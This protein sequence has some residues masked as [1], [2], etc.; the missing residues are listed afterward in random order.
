MLASML[1][2]LAQAFRTSPADTAWLIS[3]YACSYAVA[4]PM[5]GYLSDRVD[6]GRLLLVALLSFAI[7]GAGIVLAPTLEIAIAMRIFGGLA[8]AVL[9]PAAFALVS[10]VVDHERQAG[11]MGIVMLGMTVGI[12]AGPALAGIMTDKINWRAPF[13][14]NAVGCLLVFVIGWMTI[15]THPPDVRR[16]TAVRPRWFC[17]G[18][19]LRP[20]IAKGA[21]NG[22]GVAAFLLSGQVLQQRYGF[23][24]SGVGL[25]VAAFGIGLGVGNLSAGWLGK[26]CGREEVSLVAVTL[27]LVTA[28]ALFMST[29]LP[30]GGSLA[31]LI[32]WGVALGAGAP[33]STVILAAR[34]D[35]DKGMVL[36]FAETCNNLAILVAV[37]LATERLMM[38]GPRSAMSILA[39]GLGL[40]L[41]LTLLDAVL[42]RAR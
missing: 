5:F 25:T 33:S 30:L 28:I 34:A 31:C 21:W 24:A 12:A 8:S 6:R 2:P 13:L 26:L 10:D 20:L 15:P 1:S 4:A 7:D 18:R 36:A 17:N 23:G 19:V 16:V 11:A 22:T 41:V 32:C 38:H 9:I 29:P 27:L 37:P 3:S 39:I 40:G 42:V 35:A 14:F